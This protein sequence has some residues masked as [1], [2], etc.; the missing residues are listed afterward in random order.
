LKSQI[1]YVGISSPSLINTILNRHK[2]CFCTNGFEGPHCEYKSGRTPAFLTNAKSGASE[3]SQPLIS[4]TMLYS[5][6]AGVCVLIGIVVLLFSV[7]ARKRRMK[8]MDNE[9]ELQRI[10]EDLEIDNDFYNR[11]RKKPSL[12]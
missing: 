6:M 4:N 9:S 2:D 12:I 11:L 3:S 8:K 7:R 10:T 5:V 1:Y